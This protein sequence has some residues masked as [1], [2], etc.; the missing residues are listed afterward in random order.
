MLTTILESFD[1]FGSIAT[2]SSSITL[3]VTG[4]ELTAIPESAATACGLSIGNKL[5][6]LIT[7]RKYNKYRKLYEK[8]Q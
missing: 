5:N 3:S 1:T 4:I 2:A 6:N 7:I 8:H